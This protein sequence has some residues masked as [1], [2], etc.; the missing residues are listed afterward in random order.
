MD[1]NDQNRIQ[2]S[3]KFEDP[4]FVGPITG[5][6]VSGV[7][8]VLI[9]GVVPAAVD[10]TPEEIEA[11]PPIKW[12]R[13]LREVG[14]APPA[15]LGRGVRIDRLSREDEKLVMNAC[16]P[17]GHYFSPLRSAGQRYSFV[18][19]V[20]LAE[21][22]QH[23]FWWDRD[24]RIYDALTLSRLVRDNGYSTEYAARIV[25]Y[26]D[27]IQTV[28]YTL[29]AES[30]HVYR[31]RRDREWLDATEGAELRD[32]LAAYW[33]AVELPDR[34]ARAK[35]RTEYASWLKWADLL[36]PI[37]VSGL[38]ALLKTEKYQSTLQFKR[39]VP[40][41][42]NEVGIEGVDEDFCER[43][44][45]ARSEWVHGA[46]VR[47]FATGQEAQEAA[48]G[49]QTAEQWKIFEDVARVQDV[50]RRAVRR[51]IEDEEFRAVF[52]DDDAIRS[53]WPA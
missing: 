25:D 52:A 12:P 53:R 41:L 10:F 36:L 22:E 21:Y 33:A 11:H 48:E 15:E 8:D 50:L 31:L 42:A 39:R 9:C 2:F 35:W 38:E 40:A 26:E 43:I 5:A 24:D 23:P 49:P 14:E 37:L 1:Q 45:D 19:E 18:L 28:M 20:D 46:H 47:L 51:C 17:R 6:G 27:G 32:L 44:Y 30:K 4:G 7:R 3:A 16:T 13:L 29:A 34:V